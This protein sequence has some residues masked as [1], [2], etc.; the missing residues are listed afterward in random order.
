MADK[1]SVTGWLAGLKASD[2]E[3]AQALWR[4]YFDKLVALARRRLVESPRRV[5]D[6]QDVA[7]SVF[8]SLCQGAEHGQFDRLQDREELWR[9]LVTITVR[10]ADQ[11]I[12]WHLRQKRGGGNVRGD[13]VFLKQEPE[14]TSEGFDLVPGPEPTPEFLAQLNE[15]HT[16]LLNLLPD[17]TLR[18]IA[19]WKMEGRSTVEMSAE[20][21]VTTRSIERKLQRIRAAWKSE[22]ARE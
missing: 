22:L 11:Q 16:R 19:T 12:R 5:A 14:A 6:E 8:K 15:E 17:D 4:R 3:A 18:R 7:L 13:S 2:E 10:K 20:L 9:L 21:G 1:Q